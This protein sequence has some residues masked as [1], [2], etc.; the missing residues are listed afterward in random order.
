M[1]IGKLYA[2][3]I[4]M[5]M[6]FRA[7]QAQE[8]FTLD[9]CLSYAM[10]HA[11][12]I[13]NAQLDEQI[14]D[15]KVKETVGMGLPQINGSASVNDNTKLQRF[16]ITKSPPDQTFFPVPGTDNVPVGDI[17]A[18]QSPFS[19]ASS[20][21]ASLS[22]NQL[23]FNGS[24]LVGLKAASAYRE[25]SEKNAMATREQV[26]E[27]VKKAFYGAVINEERIK[28]YES[29]I[30]RVDSLLRNTQAMF[31]AGFAEEIDVNRIQVNL[32]NLQAEQDKFQNLQKLSLDLLKFQMNYP[33]DQDI[34]VTGSLSD[35]TF[36]PDLDAYY[37]DW[38][39]KQRPDYQV[40]QANKRLQELN[41]KN[42][43]AAGMPV[44]SAYANAGYSTQSAKI[45]GI[46]KT[47]TTGLSDNGLVGPDKWY[48]YSNFGL[49]LSIPI[50]SGLQR[51]RAV[52]E[53]KLT[54]LKIDNSFD[55][56][57]SGIDLEIKQA[58]T[59]YQNSLKS[60]QSQKENMGLAEHV[61]HVTK[62]K[63]EQGV[64]SNLEVVTAEA[65]LKA[66]QVNYYNALYDAMIAQVDLEKAFG[67]LD[68]QTDNNTTN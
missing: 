56:L 33:M 53:E 57:K 29:N 48:P 25:L 3:I 8:A 66:A 58:V 41:I 42:K 34:T 19:L 50:F 49:R 44:L 31:K 21:D 11:I 35:A 10:D 59:D 47:E 16:F 64:G 37:Q 36:S 27:N 17:I 15:A 23:I 60:L 6:S 26:V 39:Y 65:D 38:D 63:Y 1:R 22:V 30:A 62:V 12:G 5:L 28:L 2:L 4:V 43:Y 7:A 13:K 40:L 67:L 55:Q 52:Q 45:G 51:S 14:A 9:K 46:F 20:G 61:A 32:N 24:Y 68:Q 18:V 54:L